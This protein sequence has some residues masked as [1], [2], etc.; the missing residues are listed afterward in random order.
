MKKLLIMALLALS[1]AVCAERAPVNP[2][3]VRAQL[4]FLR[5]GETKKKEV[6]DRLGDPANRYEA[7]RILTYVVRKDGKGRYGVFSYMAPG[8]PRYGSDAYSLVL[9]FG[10]DSRLE[11]HSLVRVK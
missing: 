11:R 8:F 9:V 5:D 2:A 1:L 6:L 10:P 4:A 3:T 7:G